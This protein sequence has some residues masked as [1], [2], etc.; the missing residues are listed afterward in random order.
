MIEHREV[1]IH[2][3]SR[4]KWGVLHPLL[5][6]GIRFDTPAE[7]KSYIDFCMGWKYMD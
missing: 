3:V 7:A 6:Q 4:T 2:K 1:I 5:S